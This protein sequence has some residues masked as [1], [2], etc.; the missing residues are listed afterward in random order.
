MGKG[1]GDVRIHVY[2]SPL[3]S[4]YH[5]RDHHGRL[6]YKREFDEASSLQTEGRSD[7]GPDPK[8]GQI[9]ASYLCELI[10]SR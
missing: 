10:A 6:F 5:G 7:R 8:L 3:S 4:G 1:E 2:D 9:K